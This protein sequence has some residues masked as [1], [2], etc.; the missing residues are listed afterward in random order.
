MAHTPEE[1]AQT[2]WS[3]LL[4]TLHIPGVLYENYSATFFEIA[5]KAIR[6]DRAARDQEH[7]EECEESDKVLDYARKVKGS[8]DVH[9][10]YEVLDLIPQL[11]M[12]L[13]RERARMDEYI[14][15]LEECRDRLNIHQGAITKA[16]VARADAAIR[17]A[18]EDAK[19]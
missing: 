17:R 1:I 3:K 5:T 15:V 9:N 11:R 14:E 13:E 18:R 16:I 7:A 19:L 6:A 10:V 12:E 2:I 8:R 4:R